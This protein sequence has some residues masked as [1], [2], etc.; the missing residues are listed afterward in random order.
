MIV[1]CVCVCVCVC[2]LGMF[3]GHFAFL[4]DVGNGQGNYLRLEQCS[5]AR[6]NRVYHL[7]S[8]RG[9]GEGLAVTLREISH[10]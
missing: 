10:R 6:G 3:W 1:V 4:L 5:V 7:D 8:E 9:E 2:D